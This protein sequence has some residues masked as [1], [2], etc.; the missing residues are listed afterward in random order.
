MVL[1]K[2]CRIDLL[3][4]RV[5]DQEPSGSRTASGQLRRNAAIASRTRVGSRPIHPFLA[6]AEE[7]VEHLPVLLDRIV[8]QLGQLVV[9]QDEVDALWVF[10]FQSGHVFQH[11]VRHA[12]AA[13]GVGRAAVTDFLEDQVA[14]GMLGRVPPDAESG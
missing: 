14:A 5:R 10:R 4:Q 9:A 6:E 12:A 8:G 13:S 3:R 2:P 1:S 7:E 11:D